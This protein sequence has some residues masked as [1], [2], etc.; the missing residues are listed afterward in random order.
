MRDDVTVEALSTETEDYVKDL[1]RRN[2]AGYEE[3]GSVL[4]A[5]FRRL[6][7][8][9]RVYSGD[10]AKCFVLR[11]TKSKQ[12]IGFAGLGPLHGLSPSEGLGEVRDLVIEESHRG[13]GYG[14]FIL[15]NCIDAAREL[16]YRRLYLETTPQMEKAQKL[17]VSF[18]FRPVTQAQ[19][20]DSTPKNKG[21]V[22]GY[23]I[24]EN[25]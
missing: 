19:A 23:F 1:I 15:Q 12:C 6:T 20:S 24:L 10:G 16:G 8:L 4:A 22:P 9:L 13:R 14:G 25:L 3:A 18:G 2:L 17:F 7:N 5:T 11:D 21:G